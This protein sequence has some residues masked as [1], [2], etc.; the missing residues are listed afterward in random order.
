[1][2]HVKEGTVVEKGC[3]IADEVVVGPKGLLKSLRGCPR[4]SRNR[5]D[6]GADDEDEDSELED[7]D[8][9]QY[10]ACHDV[11]ITTDLSAQNN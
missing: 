9:G 1:M 6:S 11:L 2:V 4:G 10:R 8:E 3:L 5:G 7:V